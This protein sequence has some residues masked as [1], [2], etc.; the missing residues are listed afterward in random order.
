MSVRRLAI[1]LRAVSTSPPM[2]RWEEYVDRVESMRP[3]FA[4][5]N[6]PG[7][8]LRES[9]R[10]VVEAR[11]PRRE[12]SVSA[13]ELL[14]VLTSFADDYA[15]EPP[16][17]PF[18]AE[19]ALT[20]LDA[21]Q[22]EVALTVDDQLAIALDTTDASLL[23]A[24]L[25]LHTATRVLARGRDTRVHPGLALCLD[26]RLARG[27]AVAPFHPHDARGGDP[28]GDTYHF[29]AN[30]AAGVFAAG[31]RRTE[32]RRVVVGAALYSGPV[33]MRGV[34]QGV[35]GNRLFYGTH[36]RVDRLGLRIGLSL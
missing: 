27:R 29:W 25:A 33:L 31:G 13:V 20:V 26:E 28:L 36:A 6:P 9:L 11:H 5:T 17:V 12:H 1:A 4:R 16:R 23:E 35:F 7:A 34:R 18:A 3:G 19:G 2:P 21:F 15:V 14:T 22:G 32:L 8:R 30:V 24:V 10:R